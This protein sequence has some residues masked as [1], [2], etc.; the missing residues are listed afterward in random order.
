MLINNFEKRRCEGM[1]RFF[2]LL[3][4][5]LF[6]SGCAA[7]AKESGFWE[8]DTMYKNWAHLGYSWFG[9]NEPTVET[10]KKSVEQKW[11]GIPE[12]GPAI[13]E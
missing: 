1:K 9:Y 6:L 2:L 10:G 4:I 12:P 8:H 11:W 13:E 7:A 5:G 3:L